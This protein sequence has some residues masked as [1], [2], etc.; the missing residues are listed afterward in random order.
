MIT[1]LAVV[2]SNER[3]VHLPVYFI[4]YS[5]FFLFLVLY[6]GSKKCYLELNINNEQYETGGYSPELVTYIAYEFIGK[7]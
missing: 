3:S 4:F 1:Q 5:D 2:P 6:P 7:F